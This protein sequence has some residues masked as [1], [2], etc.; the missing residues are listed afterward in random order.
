[1]ASTGA[2]LAAAA[3]S[4]GSV[5]AEQETI[6]IE[7]TLFSAFYS[8]LIATAAGGFLE[9][10]GLKPVFAVSAPGRS[11]IASLVD[12][13]AHVVQSAP[14]QAFN[15]LAK[16]QRSAAIHFAQ[17]NEKDGFFLAARNPD[18]HFSWDK[19]R[20]KRVLVTPGVQPTAMFK[21]ACFKSGLDLNAFEIVDA[22]PPAAMA[23]AFRRGKGDY[24]HLQ[25]PGPQQLEHDG[26][27][28]IVTALADVVGPC[29]FSSLAATREWLATDPA[30]AFM[31]AYRKARAWLISEKASDIAKAAASYF[32]E[33]EPSVLA[34]TITAYQGL[35]NWSPHVEIT[36]PAFESTVDIFLHA[37]LIDR[38]YAYEDAVAQPPSG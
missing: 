7:F 26:A 4:G 14:S 20:G 2:V 34:E 25:G 13:S 32:K 36:R 16:G 18:P 30:K 24:V 29:A 11:A 21:Y 22:G 19:L 31:R 1:L 10:E 3:F 28:H 37:G 12:G 27:G 8:P 17:I 38:R 5:T 35:G 6:R 33:T 9:A 23:A 15:D